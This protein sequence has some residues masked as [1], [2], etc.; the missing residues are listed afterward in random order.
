MREKKLL[1]ILKKKLIFEWSKLKQ[2]R[3]VENYNEG[4]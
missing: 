3:I 2:F 1:G 4:F